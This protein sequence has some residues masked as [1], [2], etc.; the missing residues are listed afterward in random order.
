MLANVLQNVPCEHV[1]KGIKL[2]RFTIDASAAKGEYIL[3]QNQLTRRRFKLIFCCNGSLILHCKHG[4]KIEIGR[5]EIVLLSDT[6]DPVSVIVQ[7]T[8][9]GY[10]LDIDTTA[11]STFDG[12][13]Q[14][15]GTTTWSCEE[16]R[17]LLQKYGGYLQ[18]KNS[19]WKQSVFSMLRSLPNAEQGS[20]CVLKAVELCYLLYTR[21]PEYD[22]ITRRL[23]MPDYFA[24]QLISIG[25]YIE[26][27]LDEKL[28]ISVLCCKFNLSPTSLKNK[29]REFYGQPIHN[30]IQ[31]RRIHR[32]AELLQ[33]TNMTILQIAQSVGY[34][35][36]SQFN[37]VFRRIYGTTPSAYKKC[38]IPQENS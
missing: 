17:A 16:M 7:A 3:N 23:M 19:I 32:A 8:P 6:L 14:M 21:Q 13:C 27:H 18:I 4:T 5:E 30:W 25:N 22:K 29:F 37:I 33:S 35:S 10:C 1:I 26:H 34:E 2:Y 36:V 38:P 20:Y 9:V 15:L 24:Q 11:C 31:Y 28:T 12:I